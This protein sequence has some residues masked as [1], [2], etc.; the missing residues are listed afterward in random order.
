MWI[1]YSNTITQDDQRKQDKDLP[2]LPTITNDST[3]ELGQLKGMGKGKAP[4]P[5]STGKE[6]QAAVVPDPEMFFQS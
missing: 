5:K 3:V 2:P 1:V 4:Q 6:V